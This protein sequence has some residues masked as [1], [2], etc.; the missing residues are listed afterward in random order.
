MGVGNF[1]CTYVSSYLYI[2]LKAKPLVG[3][4]PW[5]LNFRVQIH[6][7]N[8]HR[9]ILRKRL[10]LY[11]TSAGATP[12]RKKHIVCVTSS[13]STSIVTVLFSFFCQIMPSS[14]GRQ[15]GGCH[16]GV[17]NVGQ[18]PSRKTFLSGKRGATR[19]Y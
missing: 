15:R 4:H 18:Q 17:E 14:G 3:S 19:K 16:P 6:R 10:F 2:V 11:S 8:I 1:N 5:L 12:R 7:V 13:L 9:Q